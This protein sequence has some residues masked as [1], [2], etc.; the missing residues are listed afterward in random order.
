MLMHCHLVAPAPFF[1]HTFRVH[2]YRIMHLCVVLMFLPA[3]RLLFNDSPPLGV[4]LVSDV[5]SLCHAAAGLD[6]EQN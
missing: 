3:R 4:L 5:I 2:Q 6:A 1:S